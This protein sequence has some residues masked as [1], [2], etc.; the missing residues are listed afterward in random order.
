MGRLTRQYTRCFRGERI[1]A[2]NGPPTPQRRSVALRILDLAFSAR[3]HVPAR[4][5]RAATSA[6]PS[7]SRS[8][9]PAPTPRVWAVAASQDG[10]RRTLARVSRR[11]R[12]VAATVALPPLGPVTLSTDIPSEDAAVAA[13]ARETFERYTATFSDEGEVTRITVSAQ[14]QTV[15]TCGRHTQKGTRRPG[16]YT[17]CLLIDPD[18]FR[19]TTRDQ[20]LQDQRVA[21]APRL[22][23][24]H[25]NDAALRLKGVIGNSETD[26]AETG[27][28]V[29]GAA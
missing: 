28:C 15:L 26:R 12:A 2:L 8:Y 11:N 25:A 27:C 13:V 20:Q 7:S 3:S 1:K 21:R 17:L 14:G 19:R 16:R 6:T 9:A 5:T 29:T 4:P 10:D 22:P 18:P 24:L 23:R